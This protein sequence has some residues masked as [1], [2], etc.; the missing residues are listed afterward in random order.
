MGEPFRCE[1]CGTGMMVGKNAGL[2]FH[3]RWHKANYKRVEELEKTIPKLERRVRELESQV[4]YERSEKERRVEEIT[5]QASRETERRVRE[6]TTKASRETEIDRRRWNERKRRESVCAQSRVTQL[7][8][9]KWQYHVKA[10]MFDYMVTG[11][12]TKEKELMATLEE[13]EKMERLSLLELAICKSNV[14]DGLVFS[15]MDA[16]RTYQALDEDFD[17]MEYIGKARTYGSKFV[18]PKVVE[19]M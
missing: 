16:V 19:Y 4:S 3:G 8:L 10:L 17:C 11:S 12:R 15:S 5:T 13:Y 18:I 6:I 1:I 7:G 2:H 9:P 14:C